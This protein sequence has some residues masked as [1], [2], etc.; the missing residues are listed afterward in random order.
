MMLKRELQCILKEPWNIK[1]TVVA[2]G[3]SVLPLHRADFSVGNWSR[4]LPHFREPEVLLICTHWLVTALPRA[5][6]IHSTARCSVF[7]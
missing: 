2:V 7:L 3:A 1:M 6:I 4:N 5:S